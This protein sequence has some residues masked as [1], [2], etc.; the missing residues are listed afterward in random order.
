MYHIGVILMKLIKQ[1][2]PMT[3]SSTTDNVKAEIK[4]KMKSPRIS[5]INFIRQYAR[6]YANTNSGQF[7]TLILN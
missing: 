2:M 3:N 5:S 7:S 6:A 1:I 4:S